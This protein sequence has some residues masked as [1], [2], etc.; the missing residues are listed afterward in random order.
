MT[1]SRAT[2]L[3]DRLNRSAR[4][5]AAVCEEWLYCSMSEELPYRVQSFISACLSI[6]GYIPFDVAAE[7]TTGT[8][9]SFAS[10]FPL[11]GGKVEAL[12][13]TRP[14]LLLA[15]RAGSYPDPLLDTYN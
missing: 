2:M 13:L 12:I 7:I 3:S 14:T 10:G 15:F 11:P 1:R 6:I 8:E 4:L 5:L 9:S